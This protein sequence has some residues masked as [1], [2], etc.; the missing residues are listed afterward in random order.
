M[1]IFLV[2]FSLFVFRP[3]VL[4]QTVVI[5]DDPDYAEGEASAV[6]DVWSEAR[7]LLVPRLSKAAR[8]SMEAPATGLLVFQVD[9]SSPGF[10]YNAGPPGHPQW[11][12]LSGGPSG[13]E[14]GSVQRIGQ[15]HDIEGR[16]YHTVVVGEQEWMMENLRLLHLGDGQP[17]P[18]AGDAAAWTGADAA[19]AVYDNMEAHREAFGLLYNWH[20]VSHGAGLC[21]AGWRL[22]DA[23]DWQNLFD[24]LLTQYG[25]AL[26]GLLMSA[27]WWDPLPA[28][29]SN[30]GGFSA[31]PAGMRHGADGRFEGMRS[32]AAWWSA[33]DPGKQAQGVVLPWDGDPVFVSMDAAAGLS[34]RCMRELPAP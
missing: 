29:V 20:A 11:L 33:G 12:L 31:L 3:E 34:V 17:L 25:G 13:G 28:G 4:A 5:S 32:L 7:G 26:G 21:P 18:L 27:L 1:M 30:A 24:A 14:A 16:V 9:G 19:A 2:A 8:E 10:Y 22:P 6:L 23:H 15:V